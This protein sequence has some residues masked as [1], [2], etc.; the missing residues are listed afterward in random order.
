[1]IT[2]ILP[3]EYEERQEA[4]ELTEE[5]RRMAA[6]IDE[7]TAEVIIRLAAAAAPHVR[8]WWQEVVSPSLKKTWIG[9]SGKKNQLK[10]TKKHQIRA[11]ELLAERWFVPGLFSQKLDDAYE[12]YVSDMTSKEALL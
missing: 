7:S 2:A 5:Q 8:N 9:I 10:A 11:T 12:K 6:M 4:I 3:N 1:M